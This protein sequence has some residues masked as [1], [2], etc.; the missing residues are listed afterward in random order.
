MRT[1]TDKAAVRAYVESCGLGFL[2]N[3][4]YGVYNNAEDID[5]DALPSQVSS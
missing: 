2:L 1:C 5:W 3:E 4:C